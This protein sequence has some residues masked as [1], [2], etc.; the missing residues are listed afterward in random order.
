M[1]SDVISTRPS[2]AALLGALW[3]LAPTAGAQDGPLAVNFVEISPTLA[4]AGQPAADALG[5]LAERGY[6]LVINLA[7]PESRGS[8]AEE[9]SLVAG[10]GLAYLNIPVDWERP[11]VADFELFSAVLGQAA[12]RNVLVHCQMNMR[13]SVFTFLHRVVH[14]NVPPADAFEAV[15]AVWSPAG[16][17]ADFAGAV[18]ERAG[19][20]F[21]FATGD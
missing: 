9:A 4:T 1:R 15:S 16:V 20:E 17:W 21:E 8:I 11:T 2:A 18:L 3:V 19:I 6:E 5:R 14:E 13:A 12:G 7:P 10:Q